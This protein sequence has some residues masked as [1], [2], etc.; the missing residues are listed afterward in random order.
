[1]IKAKKAKRARKLSM[2]CWEPLPPS[3][4]EKPVVV[5]RRPVINQ[6]DEG[7]NRILE[8]HIIIPVL[9]KES[10]L[11]LQSINL[12]QLVRGSFIN[13]QSH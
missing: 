12:G 2:A 9:E 7:L 5:D 3:S 8:I 13:S 6:S 4:L 10:L 1:M 11:W